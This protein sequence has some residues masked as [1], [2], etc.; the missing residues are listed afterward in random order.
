MTAIAWVLI[1]A[2]FYSGWEFFVSG[3]YELSCFAFLGAAG[4]ALW[5]P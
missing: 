4:I 2:L 5:M 3:V 1:A